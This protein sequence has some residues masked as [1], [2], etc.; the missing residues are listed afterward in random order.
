MLHLLKI[1]SIIAVSAW[2]LL[3]GTEEAIGFWVR[4]ATRQ[5]D[6]AGLSWA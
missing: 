6:L 4:R 5:R 1:L 3:R 2:S